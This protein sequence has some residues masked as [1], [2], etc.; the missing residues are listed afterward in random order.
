MPL[1]L[2]NL[3]TRRFDDLVAEMK[4]LIPRYA[5][6]W[7]N[8]NASDPGVTLIELLA[9][10]T[11]ATLYRIN[12]IPERT[13]L[14]F[15]SLL[16]GRTPDE[17]DMDSAKQRALQLFNEPYRVLTADDFERG[18]ARAST[19]VAR[20]K[21]I[22]NAS[23]GLVLVV[24]LPSSGRQPAPALLQQVK[25]YLDERRLV[26]T[27]LFVRGPLYTAV[28]LDVKVAAETNTRSEVVREEVENTLT[29][30]FD[31]LE[32]GEEGRGW[33][34]GR[35]V[36]ASELYR[37]IEAIPGVDH[38]ESIV[39]NGDPLAMEISMPQDYLPDLQLLTMDLTS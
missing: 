2:P 20:V 8:H 11:E 12:R 18:A 3:D 4:A 16:L 38:V 23:E 22:S 26:G 1:P 24:I 35:P 29:G 31:P 10:I 32:G 7:T 33:P 27:R 21:V 6:E 9:W 36:S 17:D 5:P 13:Y 28:K 39:M 30:Y 14:N 15:L 19:D 25:Q 37:L 34:F